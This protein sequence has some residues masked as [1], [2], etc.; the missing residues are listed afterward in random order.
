M[1]VKKSEQI[2]A[3]TQKALDE[4]NDFCDNFFSKSK[5]SKVKMSELEPVI[6]ESELDAEEV[7]PPTPEEV[8]QEIEK[9]V[10]LTTIKADI[11]ALMD[12]IKVQLLREQHK[13]SNSSI[14]LH[15][16]FIGN[17]GTGKTTI[18]RLMGKYFKAIGI[19]KKGHIVEVS[20]AD[21]VAAHVGGTAEKTNKVI[22][23]ALDGILFIDEAYSLSTGSSNDYGLEAINI[24]VDRME[25]ERGRLAVFF[26]GYDKEMTTFFE[27]NSGLSSRVTRKF[28]F[29]DY[30]GDELVQILK[31]ICD[32]QQ[33][34]IGDKASEL[35]ET[36]F[37]FI[38]AVRDSNFGNGR[39]VRNVF[40]KLIK[41]QANRLADVEDVSKSMLMTISD[42]DVENAIKVSDIMVT[43]NSI[44]TAL[45]ELNNYIGLTNIKD[46]INDLVN[47]VKTNKK[48]EDL[49]LPVKSMTYHAIFSGSPGT[50][51]TSIARILGKVYRS[52]GILKKGHI[53]EV[54]RSGLVGSYVG[55]TEV[56]TSEVIDQ[57]IDGIL[58]VDEAYALAGDGNDFGQIAIDTILKRM[59]DDRKRLIVIVAGYTNEMEAFIETNPGLKDRFTS[60]FRFEDYS[61]DELFG[62]FKLLAGKQQYKLSDEASV[63]LKTYLNE[64]ADNPPENFGNGRAVRNLFEYIVRIQSN[65]LVRIES[66]SLEEI[67][68]ITEVD[69]KK[70]TME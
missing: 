35:L 5:T 18:A 17:P 31:L 40:E 57:A 41:S 67:S 42:G 58:F 3:Q 53:V 20:R 11:D 49:G 65:R 32:K 62:I 61:G 28:Y 29:D 46:H 45:D 27:S 63:L 21:L 10:G 47:L 66:E 14:S 16:A 69:I 60:H 22:D 64:L 36:Y 24:I 33:Y 52:I 12:F 8:K 51:K 23:S 56:K 59:D 54:D 1:S 39:E 43:D 37:D 4:I 13:L 25:K 15:T 2:D 44:E 6:D 70:A 34:T 26:A 30:N 19:L 50:G 55:Q 9:L 7:A 48:R 68:L 38:Y